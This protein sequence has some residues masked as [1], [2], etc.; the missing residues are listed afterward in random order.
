MQFRTEVQLEKSKN[1]IDHS[2]N[3]M[4]FGS[5]FTDSIGKRLKASKFKILTNPFGTLFHPKAIETALARILSLTY[6]TEE[7]IFKYGEL[8]FSWDHHTS[9]NRT[10]L[11]ET[12]E[13]INSQL[14]VANELIQKTNVFFLTFGTSLVYKIK[15]M[16]LVV[17]NCHKVPSSHF[18]KVMLTDQELKTSLI[19]CFHLILDIHPNATIITTVSPVRH[20]KDGFVQNNWSKS[21]LINAL[22]E[23]SS[24]FKQTEYFPAYELIMDDL[25]D[26]RFYKDDYLHP[27]DLAVQYIW[28]KFSEVYF[29]ENT[30]EKINTVQK[31]NTSLAHRP[32]NP[33][34]IAYKEFLY[35]TKKQIEEAES[36][37]AKNSFEKEKEIINKMI[38]NAD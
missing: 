32:M 26:Y 4:G 28:R 11:N 34:S 25:R 19:R 13:A 21:R 14:E 22:H 37:F 18:D 20:L 16:D 33:E 36:M 17:A 31:I 3:I 23:V 38:E 5:C 15:E 9:F 30:V 8:Y 24:K 6:Y 27:N 2:H 1:K 29:D 10:N 7:E 35:K 12:L